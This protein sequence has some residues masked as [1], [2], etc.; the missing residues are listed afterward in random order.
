[1]KNEFGFS[2]Q[3]TFDGV[4][5]S[6]R[7]DGSNQ[8]QESHPYLGVSHCPSNHTCHLHA[9]TAETT[10]TGLDSSILSPFLPEPDLDY[11]NAIPPPEGAYL[12]PNSDEYIQQLFEALELNGPMYSH[13]DPSTISA[14]KETLQK[15]PTAFHLPGTPLSTIKG[16]LFLTTI[17]LHLFKA[18]IG[19][20][21]L[22]VLANTNT[23]TY[24][25][26]LVFLTVQIYQTFQY[27]CIVTPINCILLYTHTK[28]V[29]Y[30]F[31]KEG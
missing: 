22:I 19:S 28:N 26:Y 5:F 8:T 27:N 20:P 6:S 4:Y 3:E 18:C 10:K 24:D 16:L 25:F 17:S 21:C 31:L 23:V 29:P 30:F 15:Y 12:D 13:V 1:M 11:P 7:Q 2:S 14:F 9:Q